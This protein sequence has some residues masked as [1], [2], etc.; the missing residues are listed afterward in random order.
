M[1]IINIGVARRALGPW[2][3]RY[4]IS[5]ICLPFFQF[6]KKI[7]LRVIVKMVTSLKRK[8]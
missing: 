1:D 4:I 3:P 8:Q 7:V 6:Y 5:I 2:S